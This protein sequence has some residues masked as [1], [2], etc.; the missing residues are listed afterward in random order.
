MTEQEAA[1]DMTGPSAA[2]P[3][4]ENCGARCKDAESNDTTSQAP[5]AAP[6][7]GGAGG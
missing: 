7:G 6:K 2:F 1:G 5:A 4:K 3:P